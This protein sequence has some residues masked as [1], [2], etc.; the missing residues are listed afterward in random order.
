MTSPK[1]RFAAV[2]AAG[3]LA[4]SALAGCSG[5]EPRSVANDTPTTSEPTTPEPEDTPTPDAPS[6]DPVTEPT[7]GG[8]TVTVPVYFAGATPQGVRLYR[9]FRQVSAQNPLEAAAAL[10]TSGDTLDPDY[11]GLFP[12]GS[13]TDIGLSENSIVVTVPDDGWSTR[14]PGMNKAEARLAVAS[15]VYTLQGVAQARKPVVV[16]STDGG[17][18]PLFGIETPTNVKKNREL[19]TLALV[20]ITSPEEASTVSGPTLVAS[21][22]ASS[23][24]ANVPWQIFRGDELVLDGFATAE[25]SFDRLYPWETDIDISGLE[26]GEYTFVAVT[27]DPSGGEGGGPVQDTKDFTLK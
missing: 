10:L 1:I 14:A 15:L 21:G 20:N 11:R 4:V 8:L 25:G 16:Q 17:A 7:D 27:D 2:T 19:Q 13:F 12:D 24:E 22:R 3:A 6:P 23:F 26:P 9:E 18:V 5:D